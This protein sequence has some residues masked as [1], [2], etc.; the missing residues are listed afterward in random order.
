MIGSIDFEFFLKLI[1]V[2]M[3]KKNPKVELQLNKY[4]PLNFTYYSLVDWFNYRNCLTFQLIV[5]KFTVNYT[6][7]ELHFIS[8]I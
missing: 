1:I 3:C 7:E 6:K 5:L 2:Q 8:K 4:K